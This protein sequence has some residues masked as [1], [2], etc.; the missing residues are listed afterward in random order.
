[1]RTRT[2]RLPITH[3]LTGP[4]S[5]TFGDPHYIE[6]RNPWAPRPAIPAASPQPTIPNPTQPIPNRPVASPPPPAPVHIESVQMVPPPSPPATRPIPPDA[7]ER[8]YPVLA[9]ACEYLAKEDPEHPA[10]A[11]TSYA[12]LNAYEDSGDEDLE[13]A[14]DDEELEPAPRLNRIRKRRNSK[15]RGPGSSNLSRH[16]RLCSICNSPERDAIEESFLHWRSPDILRREF[17]DLGRTTIYRHAHA[18]G[19]FR[20]RSRKLRSSLELIIQE[21]ERVKP[22]A[23]GVIQA[24]RAYTSLNS[25]GE[26]IDR[27]TRIIVSSATPRVAIHAHALRSSSTITEIQRVAP[28]TKLSARKSKSNRNSRKNRK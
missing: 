9:A 28:K 14:P 7:F 8:D 21:A 12:Q 4:K 10:L 1:M 25:A 6:S 16:E 23:E 19:L 13:P 22:T 3:R 2:R 26:W 15:K 17:T 5:S 27:P 18:V 11:G 20:L 24:I